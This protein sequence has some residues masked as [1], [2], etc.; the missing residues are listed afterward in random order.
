MPQ[1]ECL[2]LNASV[3]GFLRGLLC[4]SLSLPRVC[5]SSLPGRRVE[6]PSTRY[7]TVG[8]RGSP[9][10]VPQA[11]VCGE[12]AP[13]CRHGKSIP[14]RYRTVGTTARSPSVL[15][16]RAAPP[17]GL[18]PTVLQHTSKGRC[19]PLPCVWWGVAWDPRH[20][21]SIPVRYRTVGSCPPPRVGRPWIHDRSCIAPPTRAV[22]SWT[23]PCAYPP[24]SRFSVNCGGWWLD[25]VVGRR[26][27]PPTR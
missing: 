22:I 4:L 13:G 18:I 9:P 20:G 19:V 15:R 5:D 11:R 14:V 7:R 27:G 26:V 25:C 17:A 16:W 23:L 10:G 2:S 8:A 24:L 6:S 1:L 12:T 3:N 21:K